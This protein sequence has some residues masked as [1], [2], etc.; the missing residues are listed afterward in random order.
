MNVAASVCSAALPQGQL[1]PLDHHSTAQPA[2]AAEGL[3]S[4]WDR[5]VQALAAADIE[6]VRA[7]DGRPGAVLEP[8]PHG[9]GIAVRWQPTREQPLPGKIL[10]VNTC[11]GELPTARRLQNL[12]LQTHLNTAP[13]CCSS[14]ARFSGVL[15]SKPNLSARQE[16]VLK[17]KRDAVLANRFGGHVVLPAADEEPR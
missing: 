6:V 3:P 12:I 17:A 2:P 14:S 11:R 7:W 1:A 5:T 8:G 13:A 9:L 4:L 15:A 10:T 16:W